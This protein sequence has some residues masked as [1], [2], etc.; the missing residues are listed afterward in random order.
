LQEEKL[1]TKII[2]LVVLILFAAVNIVALDL[3]ALKGLR[4]QTNKIDGVKWF[5]Y[6]SKKT[7]AKNF[8]K[9]SGGRDFDNSMFYLYISM[10]E[11]KE[12]SLRMYVQVEPVDEWIKFNKIIITADEKTFER[13]F[14][15]ALINNTIGVGQQYIEF[16]DIE[17]M[18]HEIKMFDEMAAAKEV[19]IKY[20]G[21][22]LHQDLKLKDKYKKAIKDILDAWKKLNPE[23]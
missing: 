21:E 10:K 4:K 6:K 2:T 3:S 22:T 9:I 1:R 14:N 11:N 23:G 17:V 19:T 8:K 18:P 20:Q 5:K 12:A 16:Y 15:F 13:E 7:P